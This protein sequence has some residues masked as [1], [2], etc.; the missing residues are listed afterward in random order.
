LVLKQKVEILKDLFCI[1]FCHNHEV[2]LHFDYYIDIK[3]GFYSI[4]I[5]AEKIIRFSEDPNF[6]MIVS[7]SE[8]PIPDGIFAVLFLK[9]FNY[10]SSKID[11]PLSAIEYCVINSLNIAFIGSTPENIKLAKQNLL[12]KYTNINI[13]F[14]LDGYQSYENIILNIKTFRPKFILLGLGT[15]KQE[16]LSLKLHK[17]FPDLIIINCGGAIDVL[18]G[19]VKRA[20]LVIQ[21]LNLE[22]LYRLFLQPKRFFRY[23]K[24]YKVIPIF[25][26]T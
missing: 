2:Y 9:K 1:P 12:L 8:L 15:P 22:W 25:F 24:L 21:R 5:N 23:L 13:S 11:L 14:V 4:A 18:S 19:K 26:N 6:K 16:T 7:T 17:Q 3:K 10:I 20:P